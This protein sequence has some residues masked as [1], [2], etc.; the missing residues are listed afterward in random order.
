MRRRHPWLMPLLLVLLVAVPI[1]EV[2]LLIQVGQL[3]G[4]LPT[5]LILV[6]E[7]VLGGWLMRRE[8]NRAWRALNEAFQ[9][10]RMPSGEL[11]DAALVLVG[12]ACLM[13]PGFA[14][15]VIGLFF[16]LPFTRPLARRL[17]A[18]AIAR[19]LDRAGVPTV[20]NVDSGTV[21]DGTVVDGTVGEPEPE[22]RTVR[23]TI[24]PPR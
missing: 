6:A 8:G 1:L 17:L 13:L 18:A 20:I 7:A 16:L 11:A 21:V 15:D 14:T 2:W 19:R 4:L 23:G 22:P 10:G 12:G 24:E 3:I 5:L 9:Q